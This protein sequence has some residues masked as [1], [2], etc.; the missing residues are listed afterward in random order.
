MFFA[1]WYWC[2]YF[3]GGM[4]DLTIQ[5]CRKYRSYCTK[6]L[7]FLS[8]GFIVK[9]L[10]GLTVGGELLAGLIHYVV[11]SPSDVSTLQMS[12]YKKTAVC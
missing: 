4:K 2:N 7:K 10:L 8:V 11:I 1:Q 5:R 3:G 12:S 6:E 9:L